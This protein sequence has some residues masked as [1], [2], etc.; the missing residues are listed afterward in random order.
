MII[1]PRAFTSTWIFNYVC[2]RAK[3]PFAKLVAETSELETKAKT[4]VETGLTRRGVNPRLFFNRMTE[5][6]S[7][8]RV[9]SLNPVIPRQFSPNR[10]VTVFW[11]RHFVRT[12]R[13]L[14]WQSYS[15]FF[16]TKIRNRYV[17]NVIDVY[18]EFMINDK[19]L[20]LPLAYSE[21]GRY[22]DTYCHDILQ[23]EFLNVSSLAKLK[24]TVRR[25][26]GAKAVTQFSMYV[27]K[28]SLAAKIQSNTLAKHYLRRV[29]LLQLKYRVYQFSR[30]KASDNTISNVRR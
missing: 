3:V 18:K 12:R 15:R 2:V 23:I 4:K 27:A 29:Y 19:Q 6:V 8:D 26:R 28:I 17:I 20:I 24:G 11:H 7:Q 1:D 5:P 10:C 21:V 16:I 30:S 9:T 14:S 25:F 22:I 13:S